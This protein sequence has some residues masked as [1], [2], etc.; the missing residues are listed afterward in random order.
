P[1]VYVLIDDYD[2]VV[3]SAGN[4]LLPLLELLPQARNIGLHL[5]V[6]RQAGGAARASMD[7][8]L[9]RAREMNL[10]AV[11]MS[12]PKSEGLVF[13]VRPQQLKPGRG[14][15]LHRR[16]G[17]VPVQLVRCDPGR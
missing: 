17:T 14:T 16:L 5:Y 13:G 10:P 6:T 11:L 7:Q 9:G 1:D 15:L 2:L 3:T 4:P 12:V 8:F